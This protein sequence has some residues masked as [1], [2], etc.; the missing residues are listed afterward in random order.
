MMLVS[1]VQDRFK[2]VMAYTPFIVIEKY[3]LYSLCYATY[4]CSS[5]LIL[6]TVVCI[7]KSPTTILP[8]P[9]PSPQKQSLVFSL[10][11]S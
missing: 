2:N 4:P 5:L 11:L 1:S 6:Y 7:S 3:W 10:Y 8:Y 9:L